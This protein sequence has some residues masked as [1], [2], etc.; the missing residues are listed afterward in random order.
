MVGLM[1]PRAR[2]DGA[3]DGRTH[4]PE[5]QADHAGPSTGD[6]FS[7]LKKGDFLASVD[8]KTVNNVI[9][10]LRAGVEIRTHTRYLRTYPDSFVGGEA[11]SW[12]IDH[13]FTQTR[14][15]A[16][17]VGQMLLN[18]GALRH[19]S[20][21][22]APFADGRQLYQFLHP[23]AYAS[24]KSGFLGL[25]HDPALPYRLRWCCLRNRYLYWYDKP[26]SLQPLGYVFLKDLLLSIPFPS[27]TAH[28]AAIYT[29]NHCEFEMH[30]QSKV[31]TFVAKDQ[32]EMKSWVELFYPFTV[33]AENERMEQAEDMLNKAMERH[34]LP[35]RPFAVPTEPQLVRKEGDDDDD[36]RFNVEKALAKERGRLQLLQLRREMQQERKDA[37]RSRRR[38]EQRLELQQAREFRPRHGEAEGSTTATLTTRPLQAPTSAEAE[39]EAGAD[40]RRQRPPPRER[41]CPPHQRRRSYSLEEREHPRDLQAHDEREGG[42]SAGPALRA[43]PWLIDA[44]LQPSPKASRRAADS[45]AAQETKVW[46]YSFDGEEQHQYQLTT[47]MY[48]EAN[49]D[50]EE[51]NGLELTAT[52]IREAAVSREASSTAPESEVEVESESESWPLEDP[53]KWLKRR[54][55]G[56][57]KLL[58]LHDDEEDDDQLEAHTSSSN[59]TA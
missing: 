41:Q 12:M 49:D 32:K 30:I 42:G 5:L 8:N 10:R 4:P 20:L 14:E 55:K 45:D 29:N 31:L 34:Y 54:V 52:A 35:H 27:L 15:E 39:A 9:S 11:V 24:N 58:L 38:R 37:E 1:V 43:F 36:I 6:I 26:Y 53:A 57:E 7:G 2:H 47:M 56:K 25:K 46:F 16:V 51:E 59:P 19:A 22:G 40:Q 3:T 13:I 48:R 33:D 18:H 21:Q 28:H 50:E 23:E 17:E 44:P